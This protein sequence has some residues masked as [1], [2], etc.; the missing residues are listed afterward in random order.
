MYP[1]FEIAGKAVGTYGLCAVLGFL[2]CGAVAWRLGK[3]VKIIFD[4]IILLMLAAALGIAVGGH[5]LYGF[6]NLKDLVSFIATNPNIGFFNMVL[7]VV[8]CFGGQ[9]FYGGFIGGSLALYIYTAFSKSVKR[10]TAFDI[11]GVCIPL[12]HFF[13]RIGCFM[14]GCCYGIECRF[15]FITFG[16]TLVPEING[17]RR[18]P[19]SLLEALCNLLIF[20]VIFCL[21]RKGIFKGRL[22]YIYVLLYAPIR[23]ITEFLRGDTIRGFFLGL[24]TS[25][26]ISIILFIAASVL[27]TK[28]VSR[29]HTP[30]EE[31]RKTERLF[32]L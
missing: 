12:F 29:T 5:I 23:F 28:A 9:V 2:V 30:A 7:L 17:V 20:A 31:L 15:G 19:V 16:N 22:I 14:G 27:L 8:R 4:D 11:W 25:Q 1:F 18:F 24:S 3:R 21:F 13:G 10:E 32:F 26:W 6:T